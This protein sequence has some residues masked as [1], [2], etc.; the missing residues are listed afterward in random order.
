MCRGWMGVALVAVG[1][2]LNVPAQAQNYVPTYPSPVGAAR[3]PEPIPC[4]PPPYPPKPQP[5]LVP[6][7]ISS[8]AAPMGPPDCLSLPYDHSSAFQCEN[9][10][11]DCGVYF[12]IGPM[13]LQR[14]KLGAG[15]VAVFDA[16]AA[17]GSLLPF[18][19]N[20]FVPTPTGT[21]SALGFNQI[22][23]A[24]SL[25]IRGRIGYLW[26]DQA[27]EYQSFYIFENDVTQSVTG[28]GN[29]DTLFYNPPLTFVGDRVF[30]LA[31]QVSETQGSSLW[32]NELNFRKWNFAFGGLECLVGIRY[33]RQNDM[34]G[35]ASQGSS[36]VE[37]LFGL[38][39]PQLDSAVYQVITHNNLIVGQIGAEYNLP[40][41]SWLSFAGMGKAGWGGNYATTDVS[42][43]R[44]QDS[45]AFS[46]NA[47]LN[48]PNRLT[49]FDTKQTAW[50]FGEVYTLGA[51]AD[52]H[53]LQRLRLRLG[54]TCT[55]LVGVATASDQV[56]FNLQG[57]DAR[58]TF[59]SQG[60]PGIANGNN[61]NN[62]QQNIQHG[63]LNTNGSMMY[64][65]PQIEL[66]FFF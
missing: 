64:F 26:G 46:S 56:N 27:I 25:G 42:L 17:T 30:R 62:V 33:I 35:I 1:L 38:P 39:T 16:Q 53:L 23:P 57:R 3:M 41:F 50:S 32:N 65:G 10:V 29:I 5:N 6:G 51:F 63:T 44:G 7:P 24:L 34:F 20:P 13:A 15:D 61:L 36:L 12:H 55:W 47:L 31:N 59:I 9:Y 11:Q 66:Q 45:T 58:Q 54:Y 52:F 2:C 18:P 37:E 22:T 28:P 60:L 19:P 8:L 49:A 43:S 4:T 21:G 14:S 40:V 48:R